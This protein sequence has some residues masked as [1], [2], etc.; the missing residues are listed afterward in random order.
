[1]KLAI[2]LLAMGHASAALMPLPST[3]T[4]ADGALKIDASFAVESRGYSDARLDRAMTRLVE[5][6]SRQTGIAIRGGK[7]ALVIECRAA[8]P[9]YPTLGEDESYRLDVLPQGA[10]ITSATVTGALR[11]IETFAQLVER[12]T[13]GFQARGIHIADSPRFPW[14]GLMLDVSRHWMPVNVILRNLDAMAAVKLN[15]FHWHLSDDQGFRVESRRFPKLQGLGSDGHFYTQDE[16]R[17]VI[18]YAHDRGIRV[19]PEFD[20]PGHTTSWFVGYPELAS[21]PGPYQIERKWGV[22]EPTMDP[23]RE[24]TYE[25]LDQFLSEMAA[26]FPD[27]YFH[28][29]GD[30]VDPTQWNKSAAIQA[31]AARNG[32]KDAP[33]IQ[34]YFN[35]RVEKLLAKHGKIMIGW[36]EVFDAGLS[37]ETVLQSWR[38]QASLADAA[39]AGY[40]GVLSFGYYL[41]HL[42]PTSAHYAIDPLGGAAGDLTA[43]QKAK[44][45]GGEAC[46]WSEYVDPETIDSRVW[47]ATVAIAERLWSPASVTGV[48]SMYARLE[49]VSRSLDWVGLRHRVNYEPMLE[50]IAGERSAD[51]LRVL[52]DASEALG[53]EGRRDARHYSSLVPLN[54]FVDA[55]RPESE[56]VRRLELAARAVVAVPRGSTPAMAE[57]HA[58]FTAWSD[59]D[60][61]F[62]GPNELAGLSKNLSILGSVGLQVLEYLRAGQTPPDGWIARQQATL[63]DLEKPVAEV[64]LAAVRP[65]RILLEEAARERASGGNK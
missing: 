23:S 7:T 38:G 28:I 45:L 44:I 25:F 19:I 48:D 64:R 17:R 4:P 49:P 13:D 52:A 62:Q 37:H 31:W 3:M 2:W 61:R 60:A 42:Q 36:D 11:G 15:V 34:S 41:D 39:R 22:F 57:L 6:L 20:M 24:Q 55:V 8:G 5:R 33:A 54:R 21:A 26:L 47:P 16:V 40:R 63:A 14:R 35:R 65:V 43:G 51:V 32:L 27:P 18:E 59:N 53:I 56:P 30:E 58:A 46:M 50:R 29:G 9:R 10:K 12:G 1:M